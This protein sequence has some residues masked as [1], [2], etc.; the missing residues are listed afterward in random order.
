MG[1][2]AGL[3]AGSAAA[4]LGSIRTF[5]GRSC[6]PTKPGS[7]DR[8]IDEEGV[9][10]SEQVAMGA[11]LRCSMGMS[12]CSLVVLPGKRV[13]NSSGALAS[14]NVDD[15]QP[16]NIPTFGLCQSMSNPSVSSATAAASGVLTPMPCVPN[17]ASP[18]FPGSVKVKIAN[19]A[20]LMKSDTCMC[21]YGGSVT[22]QSAAQ[23]R[24]MNG[25]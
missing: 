9:A 18:W 20:A 11:T 17:I 19:R 21:S 10:L 14:A 3:E 23:T 24:V 12:P 8:P 5:C 16:A 22:I 1:N 4:A 13:N 6:S 25:V 2:E 15:H 7:V